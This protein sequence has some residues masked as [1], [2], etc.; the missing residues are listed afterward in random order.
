MIHQCFPVIPSRMFYRSHNVRNRWSLYWN[1]RP[2]KNRKQEHW[3]LW[4]KQGSITCEH[5]WKSLD[6]IYNTKITQLFP[7]CQ[8]CL[9][10][11]RKGIS[12]PSH[13]FCRLTLGKLMCT[14]VCC[15]ILKK[16]D[17]FTHSYIPRFKALGCNQHWASLGSL[18]S[19]PTQEWLY[20]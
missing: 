8:T 12:S 19:K 2:R 3:Q 13:C 20:I 4:N 1:N 18:Y 9:H 15:Y 11:T 10:L 14:T 17:I 6:V 7:A 16:L 5:N